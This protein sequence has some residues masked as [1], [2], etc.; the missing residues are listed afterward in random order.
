MSHDE[1]RLDLCDSKGDS[2]DYF[3]EGKETASECYTNCEKSTDKYLEKTEMTIDYLAKSR[4]ESKNLIESEENTTKTTSSQPESIINTSKEEISPSISKM[5]SSEG[6]PK[7]GFSIA[8][9]MGFMSRNATLKKCEK[10]SRR[11]QLKTNEGD[12]DANTEAVCNDGNVKKDDLEQTVNSLRGNQAEVECNDHEHAH[13][14][15]GPRHAKE[16][17]N[18]WRPQPRKKYVNT[19]AF[20]VSGTGPALTS[21][22]VTSTTFGV[23]STHSPTNCASNASSSAVSSE[24]SISTIQQNLLY[25]SG[26][27]DIPVQ[28]PE[29]STIALLRQYSLMNLNNPWKTASLLSSYSNLFG[30]QNQMGFHQ[31]KP[32]SREVPLIPPAFVGLP[33]PMNNNASQVGSSVSPCLDT[34]GL[35]LAP[36][37]LIGGV[38]S[39]HMRA[40]P[41]EI[42]GQI[43]RPAT[44]NSGLEGGSHNKSVYPNGYP[45]LQLS[46]PNVKNYN[47]RGKVNLTSNGTTTKTASRSNSD[48]KPNP[49]N[50]DYPSLNVISNAGNKTSVN[51]PKTFPCAECGKVFNAHY[52]LTRHM[53]VHTGMPIYLSSTNYLEGLKYQMV[54]IYC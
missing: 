9:I 41:Y 6:S 22:P 25:H 16:G 2:S 44:I 35:Q 23:S 40:S 50:K 21:H 19:A 3:Y 42:Q 14:P 30:L 26:N 24:D 27:P 49:K 31:Q 54:I 53:P 20:Q 1:K 4:E 15:D 47:I 13:T 43:P 46:E 18:L 11:K 10:P 39:E 29:I 32:F 48:I 52:N 37:A 12:N 28:H 38:L 36:S 34:R 7:L 45:S 8:Q 5:H 51:Q 17:N 33:Y